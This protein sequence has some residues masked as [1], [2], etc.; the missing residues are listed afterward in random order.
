MASPTQ[1]TWVWVNS[2]SWWWTGRPGML[3]FMGSQSQTWLNDWT[4]LNWTDN[5][6]LILLLIYICHMH[7]SSLSLLLCSYIPSLSLSLS[8]CLSLSLWIPPGVHAQTHFYLSPWILAV[9]I[10]HIFISRRTNYKWQKQQH[11]NQLGL[12]VKRA[13]LS[14]SS[15]GMNKSCWY[16]GRRIFPNC[17]RNFVNFKAGGEVIISRNVL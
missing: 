16:P 11:K 17:E 6:V 2:G 5:V 10:T 15:L 7:T 13:A 8:L 3:Q 9:Y 1:W 4:E 14:V 12:P